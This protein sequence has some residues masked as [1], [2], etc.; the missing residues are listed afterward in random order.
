MK[1]IKFFTLGCKVNQYETQSIREQSI[2]CGFREV[3]NL[4]ADVYVI[5][6]CTVT[7]HADKESRRLVRGALRNNPDGLILATGCLVEKDASEITQISP[8]VKIIPNHSKHLFRQF[9]K[10]P[11]SKIRNKRLQGFIPLNIS[12]FKGHERAFLKIQDGC[13]NFCSYCKVP[14]VRGRSRSRKPSKI[15]EELVRL[16]D[17]G[18]KEIVLTGVCLGDYHYRNLKLVD[19]LGSLE[20]LKGNFRLRLSSIEPQL[21]SKKLIQILNLPKMC[22]HLHL[23]L[24]SGDDFILKRMNRKYTGKKFISLVEMVKGEV[25]N[26]AITTDVVVGF[27]GEEKRHFENTLNCLKMISPLRTHIFSYSRRQGTRAFDM[28]GNTNHQQIKERLKV[29]RELAEEC[30]FSYRL[31]YKG[32]RLKVLIESVPE[33]NSGHLCGYSENYIR[34]IVENATRK[35][36]NNVITVKVE[37]VNCDETLARKV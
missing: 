2:E 22:K 9:L 33:K 14:L 24:Q 10:N 29:I 37:K 34:T 17:A 16:I 12:D 36:I 3:T 21:V 11:K 20:K 26:I 13:D 28:P 25:K 32:K 35:D 30:S 18:F 7:K 8:S 4:P 15:K 23:P 27:P 19:L 5:N 6:T 1:K 31:D